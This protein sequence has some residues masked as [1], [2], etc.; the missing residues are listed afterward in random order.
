MRSRKSHSLPPFKLHKGSAQGYV[1]LDDKRRYLGRFDLPE[2]RQ[3]YDRLIAEWLSNGRRLAVDPDEITVSELTIRFWRHA[4][5]HYRHPDGRPTNELASFRIALRPLKR[6]YGDLPASQFGPRKLKA[7]RQWWVNRGVA[8]QYA[9]RQTD[10]VRRMFKWASSEE[11]VKPETWRALTAVTGLQRGRTEAHETDPV[12]PVHDDT[13]TATLPYMTPTLRA[14]AQLQRCTGM[15]PGEVCIVRASDITMDG[16]VWVFK[17][18]THK[19][20]W[21]QRSRLIFIGPRGQEILRPFLTA[22]IGAYLFSPERSESE[23]LTA[24]H[25]KRVTPLS[26]GNSPG[27]N[28]VSRP[29]RK[30][31]DRYTA[32]SYSRA[33][34]YACDRAFPAPDDLPAN[35]RAEWR[36]AHRWAPNRLRHTFATAVRREH[37][38]EAAQVLLGHAAAD[39]TQV[40]AERDIDRAVTVAAKIG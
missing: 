12:T 40:Y 7:V 13:V 9:N 5:Q 19:T 20:A 36:R 28:R 25:A 15:R 10:R 35:E 17:P 37:G 8:R 18:A 33:I 23:R 22:N 31:G 16:K 39:V 14:M 30:P 32:Q 3:R 1:N 6:L 29:G 2:T 27:T 24:M 38:L 34:V 26:C 11:V 21:R 4:E